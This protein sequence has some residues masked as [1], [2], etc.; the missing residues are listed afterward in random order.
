MR[1]CVISTASLQTPP[2]ADGYAGMERESYWLVKGLEEIGHSV[3]LIA[4]SGSYTPKHGRLLEI[5]DGKQTPRVAVENNLDKTTEVFIDMGHDKDLGHA[6]PNLPIIEQFQVMSMTGSGRNVVLIS[7]GQQVAKF[8]QYPNV[9]IIYQH[10]DLD[11]YPVWGGARENYLLYLGQVVH[12][13][14][15]DWSIRVA[16]KLNIP[17]HVVGVWWTQPDY[18]K[19][20]DELQELRPDLV[21]FHGE[22]G[23]EEKLEMIQ[24][25]KCLVH[26]PGALGFVEAGSI[27]TLETLACGTPVLLSRNGVHDEYVQQGKNGYVV[28]SWQEAADIIASGKVDKI[29]PLA[30]RASVADKH[31]DRMAAQY[32]KL[33]ERVIAG[34]TW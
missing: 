5:E 11:R 22:M 23:G 16:L 32:A 8:P 30:C 15:V 6:L 17:I 2:S 21:H 26:F 29:S 25:A 13:K 7:R 28:D 14:R 27:V 3:D 31:Y 4:K 24:K 9:P 1:I 34:D 12:E 18:K 19:M 33:C 20:L 10:I